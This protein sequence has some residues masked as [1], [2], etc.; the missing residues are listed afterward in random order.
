MLHKC[1]TRT[2][3][4]PTG[5]SSCGRRSA[6]PA[7][8]IQ[9][10][11]GSNPYS[12]QRVRCLALPSAP[13][14][15]SRPVLR[16]ARLPPQQ[17]MLQH[18]LTVQEAH[19]RVHMAVCAAQKAAAATVWAKGTDIP[20]C[21][22]LSTTLPRPPLCSPPLPNPNPLLPCRRPSP[23]SGCPAASRHPP[24]PHQASSSRTCSS[25]AEAARLCQA[26]L[27]PASSTRIRLACCPPGTS[28]AR[29]CMRSS[30]HSSWT[31]SSSSS[32]S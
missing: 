25:T 15:P 19:L 31:C 22:A 17:A 30:S 3:C 13:A 4:S 11:A 8:D 2:F 32:R 29:T 14:C 24:S 27:D 9:D 20:P 5:T 23:R 18:P 6:L 21:A 12:A 28:T 16:T 10:P 26:T 7:L 1:L